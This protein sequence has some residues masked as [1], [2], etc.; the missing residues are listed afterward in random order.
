MLHANLQYSAS[1]YFDAA[2]LGDLHHLGQASTSGGRGKP[3]ASFTL[4]DPTFIIG[5]WVIVNRL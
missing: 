3:T 5:R 4:L 1:A 2:F